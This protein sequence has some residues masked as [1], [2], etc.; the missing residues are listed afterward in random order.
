MASDR[1]LGVTTQTVGVTPD[2]SDRPEASQPK[3]SEHREFVQLSRVDTDINSSRRLSSGATRA[4]FREEVSGIIKCTVERV[5]HDPSQHRSP[6]DQGPASASDF[7]IKFEF[8]WPPASEQFSQVEVGV[9][10][11]PTHLTPPPSVID[12]PLA[13]P[14]VDPPPHAPAAFLAKPEVEVGVEHCPQTEIHV[15]V[16]VAEPKDFMVTAQAK[17]PVDVEGEP[18]D[19]CGDVGFE[20]NIATCFQCK[21]AREHCYCMRKVLFTIPEIWFCEKC[22][23]SMA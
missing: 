4:F 12:P 22:Q 23:S 20:V 9:G 2:R 7:S 5:M 13:A 3:A 8:P 17:I 6:S 18:C 19:I 15:D 16:E 10:L 11:S 1:L 21:I 14:A